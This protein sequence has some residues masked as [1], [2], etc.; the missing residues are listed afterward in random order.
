MSIEDSFS[1]ITDINDMNDMNEIY[2]CKICNY[3]CVKS[4]DLKKHINTKKH[5]QKMVCF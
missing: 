3:I 5:S 4:S 1:T 2:D